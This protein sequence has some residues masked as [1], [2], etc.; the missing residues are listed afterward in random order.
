MR[1][2]V[3]RLEAAP[4]AVWSSFASCTGAVRADRMSVSRTHAQL[5]AGTP[6]TNALKVIAAYGLIQGM[7]SDLVCGRASCSACRS[8]REFG[9]HTQPDC[10]QCPERSVDTWTLQVGELDANEVSHPLRVGAL[11]SRPFT[12]RHVPTALCVISFAKSRLTR[13]LLSR[14]ESECMVVHLGRRGR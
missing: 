3:V 5:I 2:C 11:P 6:V 9:Y 1:A 12:D 4:S 7:T 13:P 14:P 10:S 8:A